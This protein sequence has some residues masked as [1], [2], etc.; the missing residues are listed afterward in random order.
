MVATLELEGKQVEINSKEDLNRNR[1]F[2]LIR[3]EKC[4]KCHYIEE[5]GINFSLN[6]EKCI[7]EALE[8]SGFKITTKYLDINHY[9]II[10]REISAKSGNKEFMSDYKGKKKN[11][12]DKIEKYEAWIIDQILSENHNIIDAAQNGPL[13]S[14]EIKIEFI[15]TAF[16]NLEGKDVIIRDQVTGKYRLVDKKN[17]TENIETN[18]NYYVSFVGE[19]DGTSSE[20]THKKFN[21]LEDALVFVKEQNLLNYYIQR[22]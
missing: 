3:L 18:W 16:K 14:P 19:I 4:N 5:Q 1:M 22:S 10:R 7:Q 11:S 20:Y 2:F 8:S 12:S 6:C 13:F 9:K 15:D 21:T 17:K